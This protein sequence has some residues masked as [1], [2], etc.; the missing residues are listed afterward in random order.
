MLGVSM[1]IDKDAPLLMS[2]ENP[3]GWKLE[4]LLQ[5]IHDE[6]F[7]KNKLLIE[8]KRT[9]SPKQKAVSDVVSKN[10]F[11]ILNALNSSVAHQ[12]HSM[13]TLDMLGDNEG[14]EGTPRV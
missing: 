14:P 10:N 8:R 3:D 1:S 11:V 2:A 6:L 9:M 5:K 4:E 12:K 13:Q 7:E